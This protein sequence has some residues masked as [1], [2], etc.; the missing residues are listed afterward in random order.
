[1]RAHHACRQESRKEMCVWHGQRA[2]LAGTVRK[3]K[4]LGDGELSRGH[5]QEGLEV[6]GCEW[7]FMFL[8]P[9]AQ[10]VASSSEPG[11]V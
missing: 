8:W 7:E 10:D 11:S 6:E 5:L 9:P 4:W 1:M 2:S 3:K